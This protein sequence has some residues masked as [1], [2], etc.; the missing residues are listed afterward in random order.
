MTDEEI[1][2]VS[3]I[4]EALTRAKD[5]KENIKIEYLNDEGETTCYTIDLNLNTETIHFQISPFGN[6]QL[7]NNGIPFFQEN[8]KDIQS[9][10]T[11]R[12]T[13]LTFSETES[14]EESEEEK[15]YSF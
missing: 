9:V 14:E 2:N 3:K 1:N 11:F 10:T 12:T 5:R 4:F 13:E 7:L 15:D 6:V 8:I